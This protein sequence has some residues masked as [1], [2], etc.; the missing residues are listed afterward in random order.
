VADVQIPSFRFSG[1]YYHQILQDLLVWLRVSVPEITD[2]D[3]NEP[4]VQL[5]RAYALV[6]HLSNV[7]LDHVAMETLLPTARLRESVR[8]HLALLGY[9][10]HQPLPASVE[11]LA[12]LA[13]VQSLAVS[14]P[15][16]TAFAAPG[17]DTTPEVVY[18]VITAVTLQPGNALGKAW[19]YLASGGTYTDVTANLNTDADTVA[20]WGGNAHAGDML[21]L[22]HASL[23][24]DRL[25]LSGSNL[26]T[27]T[28]WQ[29]GWHVWEYYDGQLDAATPSGVTS[30][31]A[32][33]LT[34]DLTSLLGTNNRAGAVVRVRCIATG[35][36]QDVTSTWSGSANQCA[37]G[38]LGQSSLSL[39][40]ADYVIGAAWREVDGLAEVASGT[41]LVKVTW[42]LPETLTRKW[43][44]TTVNAVSG[45]WLRLRVVTGFVTVGGPTLDRAKLD[46]GGQYAKLTAVQGSTVVQSPA[47]SAT[48]LAGYALTTGQ[49]DV[50]DGS[51]QVQVDEGGGLV[52]YT[53]VQDFLSST[54]TD[55]HY[56]AD[57]DEDGRAIVTFGDG[58]NGK[59]PPAG[60]DNV[61]LTYR[62]GASTD[63]NLGAGTITVSR[64]LST[65]VA[66][67]TNPRAAS[68]W[69]AAEGSTDA[70][71]A[72]AKQ[73]GPASLR[74]LG[75]ALTAD[76]TETMAEGYVSPTTSAKPVARA[77]AFEAQYG[78]KTVGVMVAATGGAAVPTDLLAEV[79]AYLNGDPLA[80]TS[81][82][83][84]LNTQATVYNYTPKAVDVTATIKGTATVDQIK[85]ALTAFLQPL[86][87]DSTGAYV[88][89]PG[90]TVYRE[91]LVA[92]CFNAAPGKVF[93]V[94]MTTPG[95]D[96]VL[97]VNELPV[98]GT[99]TI[100]VTA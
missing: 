15:A 60:A 87:V 2:E 46:Q 91:R 89:V 33:A 92:E 47:G 90:G 23:L 14:V 53:Q 19:A 39:N 37:T 66:S 3:P 97:G 18:E 49:P 31:G 94:T 30:P 9:H 54:A 58:T 100:T 7:T 29:A 63:G 73:A 74:T 99:L 78:P 95:G 59:I 51:L 32:G 5:L 22:S 28:L 36:Y 71:L 79:Q 86:A 41:T 88:H 67:V 62:V 26:G 38:A 93:N 11:I 45:Y 43:Q 56:T 10:L 82:V 50:V 72:A 70:G 40:A 80:G 8:A 64:A 13:A 83:L 77:I 68:G 27:G 98:P 96:T 85:A 17:T 6:G 65:L 12:K 52:A 16:L 81:G 75:R 69:A 57:Y 35:V 76:D 4:F 55:R 61:V 1:L 24:W 48:G 21:Y 84:L 34:F 20:L 25:D 42:R 44:K